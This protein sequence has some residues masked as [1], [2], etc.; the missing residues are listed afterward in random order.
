MGQADNGSRLS[1]FARIEHHTL[2]CLAHST[3]LLVTTM[4]TSTANHS[5]LT[6]FSRLR[7]KPQQPLTDLSE[8]YSKVANESIYYLRLEEEGQATRALQGWKMLTT[9]TIFQLTRIDH[10]HPNRAAYTKD[11]TS[12]ESGVKELYHKALG[13]M[14]RVQ[15]QVDTFKASMAL[16][17]SPS[18]SHSPA[19]TPMTRPQAAARTMS[20]GFPRM[21]LRDKPSYKTKDSGYRSRDPPQFPFANYNSGPTTVVTPPPSTAKQ[22]TERS[23]STDILQERRHSNSSNRS[24]HRINFTTS[25]S[26]DDYRRELTPGSDGVQ[27]EVVSAASSFISAVSHERGEDSEELGNIH[28][29]VSGDSSVSNTDSYGEGSEPAMEE[30][31]RDSS[32]ADFDVTDYYDDYLD[33]EDGQSSSDDL[34]SQQGEN[35]PDNTLEDVNAEF[36]K[37]SFEG[38]DDPP[39]IPPLP[40]SP[41]VPPVPQ[42]PQYMPPVPHAPPLVPMAEKSETKIAL[43]ISNNTSLEDNLDET[44]PR[45]RVALKKTTRAKVLAGSSRLKAVSSSPTLQGPR[46][47]HNL[48][49]KTS[50]KTGF[51]STSSITLGSRASQNDTRA[52][53]SKQLNTAQIAT[54]QQAARMVLKQK[55]PSKNGASRP[56][57]TA[58]SASTSRVPSRPHSSNS[59]PVKGKTKST[60]SHTKERV[61]A[62]RTTKRAQTKTSLSKTP[63]GGKPMKKTKSL[64]LESSTYDG[65]NTERGLGS[66]IS[67]RTPAS[68]G[69]NTRTNSDLNNSPEDKKSLKEEL[70]DKIIDSIPGVD[71]MAAMQI[72]QEIVVQGDEVHW[73]DIAGLNT[74]KNSLKEA[75]VYPFLRPDLFKGLREP[76]T[77]MLLFGPPGT[78]K[79]MLARAVAHESKSTFFSISA[80]S[81]TSKYLGESEKLVRALFAVAKKL[82]PAIIFVDEIDSIL[83]SRN[84]EGE[85]ESSRRIKNEFL[86]QWSSLSSAAAGNEKNKS[87]SSPDANGTPSDT[88]TRVLVLAATNLPWSIDEAARRRFVRRQYIPLPEGET[89][90]AQFQKLLSHQK[91]TLSPDDFNELIELTDGYSGS[92]ITSLAKDAAMGPLRELG[93][94]LL[95]MDRENIRPMGLVDFKNSLVY[96]KPSVSKEGLEKY[97]EW[98]DKFGSSGI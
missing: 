7:K 34:D 63:T 18:P 87:G 97:E 69:E 66:K 8:L 37:F 28:K 3:I 51:K 76:I 62:K 4:D 54:S 95:F 21:T 45:N 39:Q 73:D 5:I 81:L 96:I 10:A 12:L 36:Q 17:K 32:E 27:Q 24:G 2:I 56:R 71:R 20:A 23:K 11:E 26:P 80:S 90:L 29:F 47:K 64:T 55:L 89:R 43:P 6:K 19:T 16:S 57:T 46:P 59:T 44:K 83:G 49:G 79:T 33:D 48:T 92:D 77:G 30:E 91:H 58:K 52:H 35:T 94:D 93:D 72:F 78:G 50:L 13:N 74:A 86:I 67:R 85:N 41:P 82:A 65:S 42:I 88:D 60:S 61:T 68:S 25:K 70:E 38:A 9:D 40:R 15:A 31:D 1:H 75:V 14:E 22:R 53:E 84:N 98:A